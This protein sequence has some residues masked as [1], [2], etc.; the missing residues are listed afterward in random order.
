[1]EA[2]I[3]NSLSFMRRRRVLLVIFVLIVLAVGVAM[4]FTRRSPALVWQGKTSAYWIVRLSLF[5]LGSANVSAEAFLFA[6][7]KDVVPELIRGLSMR[8][9]WVSDRWTDL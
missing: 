3:E 8:E 2:V 6:A 5:D 4:Y 7:G 9:N 1:M